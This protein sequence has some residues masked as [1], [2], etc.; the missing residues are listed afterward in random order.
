MSPW[1][2][3]SSTSSISWCQAIPV[4]FPLE[5]LIMFRVEPEWAAIVYV[6]GFLPTLQLTTP[7]E[8]T[9]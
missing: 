9:V 6:S 3:L 7:V 5:A 1:Q 2:F 8:H 4:Y